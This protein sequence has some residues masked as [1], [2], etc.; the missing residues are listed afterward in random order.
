MIEKNIDTTPAFRT[1]LTY[2]DNDRKKN[3]IKINTFREK[4]IYRTCFSI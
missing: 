4:I 3:I 2:S 1:C